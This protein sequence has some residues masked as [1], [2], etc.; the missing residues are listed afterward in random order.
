MKLP[1]IAMFLGVLGVA[2]LAAAAVPAAPDTLRKDRVSET[3]VLVT[4]RDNSSNE[5]GFEI[6]R[7]AVTDPADA[8][9][10]RGEVGADVR[11]FLDDAPKD[12]LFIYRVRAFNE[13]GDSGLSNECYVTRTP[14]PKPLSFFVRLI[15][16]YTVDVSWSDRSNGER[17]FEIQRA[18][19]GK[20]FRTIARVPANTEYYR[21]ETQE[22][23][24]SYVYRMRAIGRTGVCQDSSPFTPIRSVTTLGGTRTLTVELRGRGKGVVRSIPAGIVCGP[25][26]DHCSAEF[27]LAIDVQLVAN[28]K[29]RSRFVRWEEIPRCEGTTGPCSVWLNTNKTVGAVFKLNPVTP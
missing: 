20:N 22:P 19:I 26:D 4:W 29:P 18:L 13:D 16:L 25:K 28:P 2:S 8:W 1:A 11:Q 10:T 15:A 17:G 14:P 7:R 5:D 9:E 23:A 27:P 24:T 6:L 21:D 3:Q 12:V